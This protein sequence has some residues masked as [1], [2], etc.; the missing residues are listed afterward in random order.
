M[1][2]YPISTHVNKLKYA[3]PEGEGF[4]PSPDETLIEQIKNCS[5]AFF[6]SIVIDLLLK[7]GYGGT[8]EDAGRAIGRS[9]DEGID[10]IIKEDRLG[11]EIIYIQTK[12]WENPVGRPEIQKFVGALHGQHA[13]KGL[14]ITTSRFSNEA[15][16]YVRNLDVKVI[17][18]DG[19]KLAELMIDYGL[20]LTIEKTYNIYRID[21]DYFQEII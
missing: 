16:E 3:S 15:N 20:G 21:S 14:F 2:A 6:E 7:M 4:P 13:K 19:D 12:R 9:G 8:L 18:V 10:G 1:G 5:P 17:L 11:F